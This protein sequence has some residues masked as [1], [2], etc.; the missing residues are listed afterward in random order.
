MVAQWV[1]FP[2][3]ARRVAGSILASADLFSPSFGRGL[4]A[5]STCFIEATDVFSV[6]EGLALT[7][8][9]T[10]VVSKTRLEVRGSHPRKKPAGI[11][12]KSMMDPWNLAIR[13]PQYDSERHSV[14]RTC[15]VRPMEK[16][17][18]RYGR[19]PRLATPHPIRTGKLSSS[20]LKDYAGGTFLFFYFFLFQTH[21]H[22][23]GRNNNVQ[24]V[25]AFN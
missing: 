14:T 19:G 5:L 18:G 15:P 13:F 2:P 16:V 17:H 10:N 20:A 8:G 11:L 3:L 22:C 23:R 1:A 25:Q 7:I 4:N 6:V 12:A 9:F 24:H 21:Y